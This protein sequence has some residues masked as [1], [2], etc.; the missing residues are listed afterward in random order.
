MVLLE[1]D[2]T[3]ICGPIKAQSKRDKLTIVVY[4]PPFLLVKC[5]SVLWLR[6]NYLGEL[7]EAKDPRCRQNCDLFQC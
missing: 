5:S 3:H 6:P 2:L 7:L 1:Q 4:F